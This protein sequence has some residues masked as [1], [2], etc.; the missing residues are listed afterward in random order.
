MVEMVQYLSVC[1]ILHDFWAELTQKMT[2]DP[3]AMAEGEE[4]SDQD[5]ENIEPLFEDD[6]DL[7]CNIVIV[8]VLGVQ[9]E[10]VA[11]TANSNLVSTRATEFIDNVELAVVPVK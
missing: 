2:S 6:S 7:P 4:N 10:H 5:D 9:P 3:H 11:S 1:P 8:S